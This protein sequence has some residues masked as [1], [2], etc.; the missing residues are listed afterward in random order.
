LQLLV[1]NLSGGDPSRLPLH[2]V[3]WLLGYLVVTFGLAALTYRWL[4][5]PAQSA[6]RRW[7][8]GRRVKA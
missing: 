2:S 4:E 8:D 3:G 5:A 6:L 7:S 1:A